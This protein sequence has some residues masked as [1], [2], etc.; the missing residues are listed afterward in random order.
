MIKAVFFDVDG[1]LVS[2]KSKSVPEST[3]RAIE[4]LKEKGIKVCM[5]T[6]RHL[7]EIEEL[8]AKD[9]EFDGYVMQNGQLCYN[10][11]KETDEQPACFICRSSKTRSSRDSKNL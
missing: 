7:L 2:H 8:P 5:A 9:I 1:T 4:Q 6:G 11:K 10:E 3:R